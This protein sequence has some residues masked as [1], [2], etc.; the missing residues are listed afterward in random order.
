MPRVQRT[1]SAKL[2][3]ANQY[4][5]PRHQEKDRRDHDPEGHLEVAAGERPEEDWSWPGSSQS[6]VECEQR[7]R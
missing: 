6:F 1:K 2:A 3:T 7:R 5:T 4:L